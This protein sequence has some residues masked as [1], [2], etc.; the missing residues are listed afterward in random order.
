VESTWKRW[1]KVKSS[2]HPSKEGRGHLP[3]RHVWLR[4]KWVPRERVV[5]LGWVE[6]ERNSTMM[7]LM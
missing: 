4:V 5:V 2:P 3:G 7:G 1:G 6:D